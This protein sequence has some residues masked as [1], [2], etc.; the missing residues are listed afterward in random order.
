[1]VTDLLKEVCRAAREAGDIILEF[2]GQDLPVDYKADDSPLTLADRASHTFL[3]ERLSELTPGTPVLSEESDSGSYEERKSWDTFWCVDPLDGTKE[4]VKRTTGEF[5]VNIALIK[6][7][8]PV[9][10][11]VH[12]P[13]R[14]LTYFA[15]KGSQP[16][17]Q[18]GTAT[19]Q[20][21]VSRAASSDTLTVV[22]SRDHAGPEVEAILNEI[23]ADG[24]PVVSAN[25]GSSLK[26]CLVAEGAADFYPRTVPTFEW[27]TA[28]AQCIV[29]AA[30]GAVLTRD[31]SK[32]LYNKDDLRNPSVFTIGDSDLSWRKWI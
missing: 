1:M 2:Y 20:K 9:L 23:E 25:M 26:F 31:G 13:A 28:A 6:G 12:V 7:H 30:G 24:I 4:F 32:L 18:L 19:P 29:E 14:N 15:E 5:T 22:A 21:I 10:G 11:V 8:S 17:K 3:V 16:F 27:D